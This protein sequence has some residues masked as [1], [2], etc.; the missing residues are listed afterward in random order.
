MLQVVLDECERNNIKLLKR[1]TVKVG[2]LTAVVPESLRFWF[3]HLINERGM[4]DVELCIETIS[5]KV[6]CPLCSEEQ[7]FKE[8]DDL[9]FIC[10]NCGSPMEVLNGRELFVSEIEGEEEKGG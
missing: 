7:I 10:N 4:D 5:I 1:V 2:A 9:L 6:R 3:S 8:G